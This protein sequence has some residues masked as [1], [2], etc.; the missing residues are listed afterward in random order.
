MNAT[1]LFYNH[2]SD[3]RIMIKKDKAEVNN[4]TD[5]LEYINEELE[6][7][8][9]IEDRILN[10][11]QVYQQLHD[12]RRENQLR[13]GVLYRYEGTIRNA[14]ECDTTA[15]DLYYLNN[16]EKNRNTY[17]Q[18]KRKYRDVKEKVLSMV[19]LNAKPR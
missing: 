3:S 12:V 10:N 11:A 17:V 5:D 9:D 16:H 6:Y 7:L 19:L 15:C 14:I 8:L 18:H 1:K 2:E 13:L 4:W